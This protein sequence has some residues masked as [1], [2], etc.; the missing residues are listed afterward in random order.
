M[1]TRTRWYK[2]NENS[3]MEMEWKENI[4]DKL[5]VCVFN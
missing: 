3:W 4:T 5:S 2:E 1:W